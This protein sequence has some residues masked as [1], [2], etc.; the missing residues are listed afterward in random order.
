[1]RTFAEWR[2]ART[3]RGSDYDALKW[4]LRVAWNHLDDGT[5]VSTVFL[6]L[7]HS[8]GH[9]PPLLYETMV[10]DPGGDEAGCW[11]ESNRHA[12]LARHDQVLTALRLGDVP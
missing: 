11:R 12:A 9:G 1:M 3:I 10:F 6:G 7:D 2:E 8:W 4:P 5:I